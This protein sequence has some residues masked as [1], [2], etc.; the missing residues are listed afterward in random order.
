MHGFVLETLTSLR[1][2]E[3]LI[4]LNTIMSGGVTGNNFQ[5]ILYFLSLKTGFVFANNADHNEMPHYG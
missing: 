3:F 4:M 1:Q 2:M 5:N